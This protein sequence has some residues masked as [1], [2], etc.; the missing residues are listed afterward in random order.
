MKLPGKIYAYKG[1]SEQGEGSWDSDKRDALLVHEVY[2]NVAVVELLIEAMDEMAAG[3]TVETCRIAGEKIDIAYA[4]LKK[5][6]G[7]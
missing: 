5:I 4:A 3:D 1:C 2:I 7:T 6:H